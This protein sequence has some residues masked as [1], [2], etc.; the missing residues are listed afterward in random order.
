M[1]VEKA[2]T[3]PV[4]TFGANWRARPF[5]K[6]N[7]V[8]AERY[9][10][11]KIKYTRLGRYDRVLKPLVA[12][13]QGR[14]I[15]DMIF[16][17]SHIADRFNR[18]GVVD[19]RELP[20]WEKVPGEFKDSKG[21]WVGYKKVFWCMVYNTQLVDVV[22]LPKTWEDLITNSR[23]R[24]K[25]VGI[26]NRPNHWFINMWEYFGVTTAKSYLDRL[27]NI[28]HPQLRKESPTAL[29]SL[30]ALGEFDLAFPASLSRI[31]KYAKKGA[32]ISAHCP[33]PVPVATGSVLILKGARSPNSAKIFLNWLLS[34]EGQ[35]VQFKAAKNL[36]IRDDATLQLFP[37]I[38]DGKSVMIKSP[39]FLAEKS[40]VVLKHWE[41]QWA[42]HGGKP[43]RKRK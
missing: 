28:V 29:V 26:G 39:K 31:S 13:S 3:E 38:L 43:R 19:L 21:W 40:F 6:M 33:D 14:I 25:G 16:G 37:G 18:Y 22:D 35:A 8:F 30:T 23:W 5:K 10:Y 7:K 34:R 2:K 42:A 24:G 12:L 9:P 32:P 1:W 20:N 11:I 4:L 17:A 36:P 41:E 15:S 27:L